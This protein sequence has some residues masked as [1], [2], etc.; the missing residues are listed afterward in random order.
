MTD[1]RKTSEETACEGPERPGD[2]DAFDTGSSPVPRFGS[3]LALEGRDRAVLGALHER[4][5][6]V[7]WHSG[8][9]LDAFECEALRVLLGG[10]FRG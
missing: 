3:R 10:V 1:Q 2:P 8:A 6:R 9:R 7:P 5:K 4:L